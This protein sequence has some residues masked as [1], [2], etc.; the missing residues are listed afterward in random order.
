MND[1]SCS[2]TC[3]SRL[4]TD[5][6]WL[7]I[8][9]ILLILT[10]I[11]NV[12]E[13][14]IAVFT[15]YSADS[16]ALLGFGF[17]SLLEISASL[18]ML[19]RLIEQMRY[20]SEEAVERAEASVHRFIGV[21]FILLATYIA[22]D[23]MSTLWHQSRPESTMIGILLLIMP[24]LSWGK[25]QAAA[26]INSA[27]LRSE[28]KATIACSILSLILLIGL[29]LNALFG[30]WW[31]DPVAALIMIPWLIKEGFAGIKGQSCCG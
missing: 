20:R 19:W 15:G 18:L 6:Q 23:A 11:Y 27:A 14:L 2:Q 7:K 17:D 8:A 5:N 26:K 1:S 10:V 28:A 31:A 3:G 21:T 29:G 22:F 16:V 4:K 30:W 12:A 24:L 13:A 9:F 25:I